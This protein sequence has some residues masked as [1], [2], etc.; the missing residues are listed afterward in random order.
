MRFLVVIGTIS[1][2]V[3]PSVQGTAVRHNLSTKISRPTLLVS[4]KSA[5]S[6]AYLEKLITNLTAEKYDDRKAAERDLE[7]LGT[8]TAPRL[9]KEMAT[10]TDLES[11]MRAERVLERVLFTTQAEH[12]PEEFLCILAY[13]FTRALE[14]PPSMAVKRN[15]QRAAGVIERNLSWDKYEKATRDLQEKYK[16]AAEKKEGVLD[17]IDKLE[18]ASLSALERVT[19][20]L[21]ESV[22]VRHRS[23]RG[24][25]RVAPQTE[26]VYVPVGRTL[27]LM[28]NV[29]G[30]GQVMRDERLSVAF[31]A[32]D[33]SRTKTELIIGAGGSDF[34]VLRP[35]P[36]TPYS[37]VPSSKTTGDLALSLFE[38][39]F[40]KQ[41]PQ[42]P[43]L[44][45]KMKELCG[46]TFQLP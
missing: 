19:R 17:A 38:Q 8:V 3:I 31:E 40:P 44:R 13:T 32:L 15:L 21:D 36:D 41:K 11:R 18:A 29:K 34:P 27:P 4:E 6:R 25:L 24:G 9:A 16:R 33:V 43:A 5:P 2:L 26:P 23:S 10:G 42:M 37:V 46:E 1:F 12:L 39:G 35:V 14:R 22:S 28:F 45:A 7:K 20:Q 30:I